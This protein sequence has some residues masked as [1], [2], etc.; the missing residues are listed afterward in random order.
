MPATVA[1]TVQPGEDA[2]DHADGVSRGGC[3]A[4][5]AG[6]VISVSEYPATDEELMATLQNETLAHA[7]AEGEPVHEVRVEMEQD[8]DRRRAA[9]CGRPRSGAAFRI[10]P[11]SSVQGEHHHA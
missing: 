6:R 1:K 10:T 2:R 11:G 8:P 4:S 5:S 9:F 7:L 3:T